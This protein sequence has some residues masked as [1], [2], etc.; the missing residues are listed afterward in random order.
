[1]KIRD[2]LHPSVRNLIRASVLLGMAAVSSAAPIGQ[3]AIDAQFRQERAACMAGQSAQDRSTCLREAA[4]ALVEARR[5]ALA[6]HASADDYRRNALAR[7]QAQPEKD[8]ED[9]RALVLG[10]VTMTSG[11]VEQGGIFRER[12]TTVPAA[13]ESAR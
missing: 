9:C 7:C 3:S 4:A 2:H 8:R 10:D 11:S 6:D 1:M 5:G 13:T 12:V